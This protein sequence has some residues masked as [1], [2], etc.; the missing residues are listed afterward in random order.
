MMG[1][2]PKMGGPPMMGGPMMGGPMG[3]PMMGM[4]ALPGGGGPPK[5]KKMTKLPKVDW[6][7]PKEGVEMKKLQIKKVQDKAI[8][9]GNTCHT[10]RLSR[11]IQPS[12]ETEK[13]E[14]RE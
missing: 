9:S 12:K 5:K 11:E 10:G 2:P 13:E 8:I 1:G 7:K 3:P 14:E 4:G 6:G